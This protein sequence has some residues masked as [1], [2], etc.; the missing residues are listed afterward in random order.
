MKRKRSEK[1]SLQDLVYLKELLRTKLPLFDCLELISEP[2]NERLLK[3]IREKLDR[4]E[5]AEEA[6]RDHLPE[7]LEE[8]LAQ[9][10]AQA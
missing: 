4:G 1:I 7:E 10:K 2:K 8:H 3:E 6:F 5:G 9:L